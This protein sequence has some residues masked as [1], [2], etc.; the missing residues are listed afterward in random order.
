MK[1][2]HLPIALLSILLTLL[3]AGCSQ[4]VPRLLPL[5]EGETILAFGDSLTFGTGAKA[6]ESYPA[7][8]ERLSGHTVI[9]AGVP[10]ERTPAGLRRLPAVLDKHQPALLLLCHGGNDMLRKQPVDAMADNLKAMIALA[11]ERGIQVVLLGV[12]RPALFGLES[13]ETYYRVAEE[14]AVPLEGEIVPE[15]LSDSD[16]KSDK[17]H[18]N[19][20]GYRRMAEA[21]YQLLQR[22]GAL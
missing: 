18:P 19:P 12:P 11:R 21:V 10:G 22:Q 13:A 3:L 14:L 16:L 5:A 17:I 4:D 8:L 20:E 15:V 9:N 1:R 7:I 6:E 2:Y